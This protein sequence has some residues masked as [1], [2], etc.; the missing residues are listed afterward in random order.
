MPEDGPTETF[1]IQCP[2]CKTDLELDHDYFQELAGQTIDCPTCQQKVQL[3]DPQRQSGSKLTFRQQPSLSA[4]E[5]NKK[6]SGC[7]TEIAA[8]AVICVSCG[9]NQQTGKRVHQSI[10]PAG[11]TLSPLMKK[12]IIIIAPLAILAGGL[13]L[14]FTLG[15]SKPGARP[16][17]A[18]KGQS[19]GSAMSE[20]DPRATGQGLHSVEPL[21]EPLPLSRLLAMD[22]E[23][24]E[25]IRVLE[26]Q[27]QSAVEQAK[28]EFDTW[29]EQQKKR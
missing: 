5:Q 29:L 23:E 19:S 1:S 9:T 28:R 6:C 21:F 10:E 3:P 17:A 27:Y 18:D 20:P 2:S 26:S 7:G 12:V 22:R 16:N 15:T 11:L 8:D 14:V 4:P 24:V 25:K 13:F